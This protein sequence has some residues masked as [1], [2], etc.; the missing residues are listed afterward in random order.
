MKEI[1]WEV[2]C[3]KIRVKNVGLN[4]DLKEKVNN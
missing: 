3:K 4:F 2:K 1:K